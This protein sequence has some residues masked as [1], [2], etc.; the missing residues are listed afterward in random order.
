MIE[1]FKAILL[2]DYQGYEAGHI[3]EVMAGG[4]G[5]EDRWLVLRPVDLVGSF[6]VRLVDADRAISLTEAAH[7]LGFRRGPDWN[8]P[9]EGVSRYINRGI[10]A[11]AGRTGPDIGIRRPASFVSLEATWKMPFPITKRPPRKPPKCKFIKHKA[12]HGKFDSRKAARSYP[13]DYYDEPIVEP[14]QEDDE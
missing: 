14:K 8:V 2:K 1:K 6:V 13:R 7:I 10:L 5:F 9:L 12:T 3:I 4:E 11:P